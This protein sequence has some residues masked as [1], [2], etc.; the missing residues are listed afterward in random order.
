VAGLHCTV[1]DT[2]GVGDLRPVLAQRPQIQLALIQLAQQLPAPR[3]ELVF[4]LGVG[5]AGGLGP[6]Q[7]A[8]QLLQAGPRARERVRRRRRAHLPSPF[9]SRPTRRRPRSLARPASA[10]ASSLALACW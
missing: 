4:Q 8:D 9:A 7:P 2:L 6:L 10:W 1:A 3:I 5:Q